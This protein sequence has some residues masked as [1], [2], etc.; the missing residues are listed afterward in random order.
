MSPNNIFPT[1]AVIP[2]FG[3]KIWSD[4]PVKT[5]ELEIKSSS[6][7]DEVWEKLEG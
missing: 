2:K 4:T 7:T 6:V 3:Y 5:G 1:N